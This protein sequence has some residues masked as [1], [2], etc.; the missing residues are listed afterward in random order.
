MCNPYRMEDKDWVSQWAQDAERLINPMPACQMNPDQMG[1]IIRNAADGGKQLV[2]ARWG[3]PSPRFS[4]ERAA[5]VKAD[6]LIA[7]GRP[8]DGVITSAHRRDRRSVSRPSTARIPYG[9]PPDPYS[10]PPRQCSRPN[11][12]SS[13]ATAAP[14]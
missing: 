10:R 6:R 9:M 8:A 2:H 5:K 14:S 3:L 7:K 11:H 1:P 4:L 13:Q 12:L